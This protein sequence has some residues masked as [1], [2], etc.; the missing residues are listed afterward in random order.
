MLQRISCNALVRDA[1]L[2]GRALSKMFDKHGYVFT[3]L[4]ERRQMNVHAVETE[5]QVLSEA[6]LPYL[7]GEVAISGGNETDVHLVYVG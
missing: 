5:E 1:E 2:V 6:S 3:M 4:A 7:I